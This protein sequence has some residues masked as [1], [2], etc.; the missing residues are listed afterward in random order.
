MV[1]QLFTPELKV[2]K[3]RSIM[4][5][6]DARVAK[7]SRRG[8][9]FSLVAFAVS[10][11]VGNYANA[12]PVMVYILAAGLIFFSCIRSYY[13]FRFDTIYARGPNR[14]R[15]TYF[16]I[17]LAG[18]SWWS[19][20]VVN[21]TLT[22]GLTGE[23]P[24]LWIYTAV[25]FSSVAYVFAPYKKFLSMYLFVGLIPPAAAAVILGDHLSLLFGLVMLILFLMLHHQGQVICKQ[26]WDRLQANYDLAKRASALEAERIDTQSSIANNQVFLNTLGK[27]LRVSFNDVLGTLSL[28]EHS[29]LNSEQQ[30]LLSLTYQQTQRQ[31]VMINNVLEFANISENEFNLDHSIINPRVQIENILDLLSN[32]AH[33]H[34]IELYSVFTQEL[35]IRIRCD[36][37]RFDQII[38][39]L[40]TSAFDFCDRGELIVRASYT[41]LNN[42]EGRVRVE[43]V[44]VAPKTTHEDWLINP[45]DPHAASDIH[46]GL[47]LAIAKKIAEHM[48][49]SVGVEKTATTG[50]RFWMT[51]VVE[52]VAKNSPDIQEVP[53]LTGKRI[54]LF[55]PPSK[56]ASTF[57][58]TLNNWGLEVET[59][60]EIERG[61][62][63][64]HS[65]SNNKPFSGVF[66]YTNLDSLE[67]IDFADQIASDPKLAA[68][69]RILVISQIQRQKDPVIKHLNQYPE[70]QILYK[71]IQH[72]NVLKLLKSQL[73]PVSGNVSE[74]AHHESNWLLGKSVLLF[75]CEEIEMAVAEGMLSKLG[76]K[77]YQANSLPDAVDLSVDKP[78]DVLITESH[79]PDTDIKSLLLKIKEN[80]M[81]LSGKKIPILALS[82]R[83]EGAQTTYCLSCGVDDF[84]DKPLRFEEL[85]EM[86]QRWI[87]RKEVSESA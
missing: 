10:M 42:K 46:F 52:T 66:I 50:L 58:Q 39:N 9:I 8:V 51:A 6:T 34:G 15:N 49:G 4:R 64:L 21:V 18:A 60:N 67:S 14:W 65:A 59:V 1:N 27:E 5:E 13:L 72:K 79:L 16:F 32:G 33:R 38:T 83:I 68:V 12:K 20:M 57:I 84:I 69:S 23:T 43:V 35:P 30:H 74:E 76:C 45:F 48:G 82:G 56:I 63:R 22:I 85:E 78:F 17:S 24:L 25:F 37:Y 28:L 77:V 31:S 2:Q 19:F 47:N 41:Y 40:L 11:V 26:Y 87:G 80:Q 70:T 53:K 36:G 71:P 55:R 54:L 86:L 75:Q 73:T 61:I 7:Y 81:R 62:A 3:Q 29:T 44:N